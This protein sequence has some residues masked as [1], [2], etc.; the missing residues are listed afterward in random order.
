MA[1]GPITSWQVEGVK[2]ERVTHFIFLVFKITVDKDCG[3]ESKIFAPWKESYGKPR[4]H[5]I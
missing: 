4:Q 1:S 3:H 5:I 2:R